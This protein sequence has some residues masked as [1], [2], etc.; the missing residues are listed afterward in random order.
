MY[1]QSLWD[2]IAATPDRVPVREWHGEVLDDR[3]KDYEAILTPTRAG[4]S[5]ESG[6]AMAAPALAS[7]LLVA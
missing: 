5:C 4:M 1:V 7:T 2:R 3:L 6:F